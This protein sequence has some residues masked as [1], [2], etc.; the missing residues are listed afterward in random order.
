[1]IATLLSV[2][3]RTLRN[4]L[5]HGEARERR[6]AALGLV[7]SAGLI[8]LAGVLAYQFFEPFVAMAHSEP[9][10]QVVLERLP[11]FA[12]FGVFWMLML[13]ALTV[14]IQ[15]F[16]LN[17]EMGLLLA[18][19]A[20]PRA[21]FC[22]KFLEATITNT[23]LFLTIGAPVLLA[24]GLARGSISSPYLLYVVLVLVPYCAIPT[25]IGVV[26]SI[27]LMRVLPAHRSRDLLA[28]LGIAFFACLYVVLSVGAQRLD[29]SSALRQTTDFLAILMN[30]QIF[31][32]GPWDWAGRVLNG[33]L[34]GAAA[35]RAIGLLWLMGIGVVVVTSET[36]R[37]LHWR[38]WAA[39]QESPQPKRAVRSVGAGLERRLRLLPGPLR[40]VLLKDLRSLWRDMRQLS[41]FFIPLAVIAVFL[42]NVRTTPRLD[43][44]PSELLAQTLYPV[45][46]M[47][48]MRLSMSGF[49]GE[50]RALWLFLSS[51]NDTLWLIAGKFL[52]AFTLGLPLSLAATMIYGLLRSIGGSEWAL[53]LGLVTC[54]V[55]GFSG[56]G[57]GASAMLSDFRNEQAR[58]TLSPGGRLITFFIQMGYLLVISAI[59]VAAWALVEVARMPGGVVYLAAGSLVVVVSAMAVGLPMLLAARRLRG[60]EW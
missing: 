31:Q 8:V 10:M 23:A 50:N 13:S 5:A 16:Y 9:G 43:R 20:K 30:Q 32:K 49:V 57:V 34:T 21:V 4:G 27:L 48:A 55:A 59:T 11:S 36:A 25:G 28:A 33:E 7:W 54:A 40:G 41:L 24:Y 58:F 15:T 52:Y 18:S 42:V 39:A 12:T 45:L 38:G 17:Q 14:G 26:L 46:A 22:A 35:W 60:M 51:P 53:N 6:R 47:I 19:P 37:W 56:I 3:W 2:R 1:M 44:V 29:D